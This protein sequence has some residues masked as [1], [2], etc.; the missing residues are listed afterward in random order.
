MA[1]Q[2][3][4]RAS[5]IAVSDDPIENLVH[6]FQGNSKSVLIG[7]GA[8]AAAGIGIALYRS[9]A[10]TSRQRAAS[11]L[12]DAQGILVQ[13]KFAEA[14]GALEKVVSRYGSTA[15]GRQAVV[16]L[17]QALFEQQKVDDGMKV[18]EKG[19]GGAAGED[20][21]AVE[22]MLA[23]GSEMKRD[24][25]GAA[26]HYAKAAEASPVPT[27]KRTFQASQARSLMAA[28]KSSEAKALWETLAGYEG[29]SVSQE[30][31]VRIGEITAK[32]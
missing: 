6:W 10:A 15:S 8:I 9:T 20:R 27:E 14:Q 22:A 19:L 24:F 25:A 29:E 11:A 17:A 16:L 18:L 23:A 1:Q 4:P 28:G 13:G 7:A 32:N 5:G 26:A 3:R 12:S 31:A 30:A 2:S 21:A